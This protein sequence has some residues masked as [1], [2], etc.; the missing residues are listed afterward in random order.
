[1]IDIL[2]ELKLEADKYCAEA[3]F[4]GEDRYDKFLE[5]FGEMD[6]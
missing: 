2:E 6:V 1:M 3:G 5:K 4:F